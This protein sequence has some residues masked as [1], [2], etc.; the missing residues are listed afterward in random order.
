MELSDLEKMGL[1]RK[2]GN[3]DASS[4]INFSSNDYLALTQH[5]Q[6][7]KAGIEAMERFGTGAGSSRLLAGT[8]S[9]H[10]ELE[11]SLA[12]FLQKEATLVFSSGYH[13]N[14]GIFSVLTDSND[15]IIFDRL[16]HASII[17]GIRLS[18]TPF[19]SFEHNDLE[20]LEKILQKQT[21]KARRL[22]IV[23]EGIFSMD[24]DSPDF[25]ALV[26]IKEKWGAYLFVDEAHS[27]GVRGESGRGLAFEKNALKKIDIFVGTLSKTLAS[28]GG[29]VA[30]DQVIIDLLIS[31]CRSFLFTT[32]L[33]PAPT[34]A[35][36]SALKLL[37]QLSSERQLLQE[38]SARLKQALEES[39]YDCMGS[40]SQIIPIWT[41][42]VDLTKKLSDHLLNHGFFV[43]SIRPPTVP[44][45]EGRVR[46]SLTTQITKDVQE[47]LIQVFLNFSE[48]P[49]RRRKKV[50]TSR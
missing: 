37:P 49:Q 43:P 12:V 18:K 50:V 8:L 46:L 4:L 29:F 36:L 38:N 20:D 14:S 17:D 22:F 16:C 21:S 26:K 11:K 15:L 3:R 45:A 31:K 48:R 33:A 25:D 35:A 34:A 9:I 10:Q 13:L 42:S 28:Q 44:P 19:R 40:T 32:A 5:P 24:G 1:R 47:K 6:V 30:A 7:V 2:L 41:G 23:T 39:G 27:F